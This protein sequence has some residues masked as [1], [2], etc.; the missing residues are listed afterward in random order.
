[1]LM[2]AAAMPIMLGV[3]LASC[4]WIICCWRNGWRVPGPEAERPKLSRSSLSSAERAG[5]A[6]ATGAGAAAAGGLVAAEADVA[7]LS[8]IFLRTSRYLSSLMAKSLLSS[9]I[10]SW[11]FLTTGSSPSLS[12]PR[13]LVLHSTTSLVADTT[14]ENSLVSPT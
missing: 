11:M 3:C 13:I 5:A 7:V 8:E 2:L 6:G 14:L 9:L 12:S 1:M 4:C 10:S